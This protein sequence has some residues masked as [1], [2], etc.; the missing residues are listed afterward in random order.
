MPHPSRLTLAAGN[1]ARRGRAAIIAAGSVL[2][3]G[4]VPVAAAAGPTGAGPGSVSGQQA[5]PT[6]VTAVQ[7]MKLT[8]ADAARFDAFGFS[9]DID[10]D[11][12]LVSAFNDDRS[13]GSA[14]VFVLSGGVWTQQAK[15]TASDGL[16]PDQFGR[17]VAVS[18]DIAVVGANGDSVQGRQAAGSAY[19]F[20]RS[21][22]AWTQQ[23]KLTASD[24]A[25]FD[26][27]GGSV[28]IDGETIVVGA[29]R[30]G[31]PGG[32]GAGAA[33]V[34]VR[35]ASGW[36]QQAELTASDGEGF[37]AFG[38]A[39]ALNGDTVVV[40]APEDDRPQGLLV[41][42]A[43]VFTRSGT[44]WTQTAQLT[45]ADGT[46]VDRF[47]TSVAVDTNTA[48]VGSAYDD[49]AGQ[50]EA[51][52]AYVFVRTGSAWTRQAKLTAAGGATGDLLG[53]AVALSGNTVVVGAPRDDVRSGRFDEGSA[54]VFVRAGTGWTQRAR[55]TA[56]DGAA[57][58]LFG[59][60]VAIDGANAVVGAYSDDTGALWDAGS[61]YTFQR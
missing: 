48:V 13:R 41:G 10:G 8:A 29:L 31:T 2:A 18:G 57:E 44:A 21:G 16:R 24:G 17:S 23:A 60:S 9:V 14:Y 1:R 55:L 49:V 39:V 45:A 46:E 50:F 59:V 38:S 36:T 35:S 30:H 26:A 12:A 25:L 5:P 56:F 19:V 20:V 34:F 22:G 52:S 11:T 4:L 27:F 43:Y 15:L 58:D 33:Y 40:G 28:D 47:G 7:Q 54:V 37:D 61:A 3:V 6:L 53:S 42:S 51:G 32:S